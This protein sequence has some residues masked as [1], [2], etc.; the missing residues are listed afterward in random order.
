MHNTTLERLYLKGNRVGRLGAASLAGALTHTSSLKYLDLTNNDIG[1]EG[2]KTLAAALNER[3]RHRSLAR[4][5][6]RR[7]GGNG[8]IKV[9]GNTFQ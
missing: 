6:S 7:N 2:V 9:R 5:A 8:A 4:A 1:A 3:F